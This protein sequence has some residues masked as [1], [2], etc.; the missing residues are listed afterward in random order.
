MSFAKENIDNEDFEIEKNTFFIENDDGEDI[1]CEIL[2]IY[3]DEKSN[4]ILFTQ[5]MRWM[6]RAI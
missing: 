1:K 5:K 4:K 2:F 3:T 6:N